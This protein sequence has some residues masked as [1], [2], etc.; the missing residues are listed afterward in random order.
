MLAKFM[1][2]NICLC[3]CLSN[4]ENVWLEPEPEIKTCLR[5]QKPRIKGDLEPE[6][7]IVSGAGARARAGETFLRLRSSAQQTCKSIWPMQRINRMGNTLGINRKYVTEHVGL[8]SSVC[9]QHFLFVFGFL[10]NQQSV[11]KTIITSR[12]FFFFNHKRK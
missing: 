9:D 2:S 11:T 10:M 8:S 6:L 4:S 1:T 7:E 3:I 12:I 5:E